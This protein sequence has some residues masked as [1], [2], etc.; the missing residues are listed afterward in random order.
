M[1]ETLASL[2]LLKVTYGRLV[3]VTDKEIEPHSKSE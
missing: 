3:I 1:E 2:I